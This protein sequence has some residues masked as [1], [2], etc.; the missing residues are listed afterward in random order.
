MHRLLTISLVLLLTSTVTNPYKRPLALS[1]VDQSRKDF[2]AVED[3][4]WNEVLDQIDNNAISD[5]QS[6]YAEVNLIRQF[7]KFG[8]ILFKVEDLIYF[9][10]KSKSNRLL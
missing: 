4:L 7:E 9:F 10:Y 1:R 3:K 8:D 2:L 6:T 5:K